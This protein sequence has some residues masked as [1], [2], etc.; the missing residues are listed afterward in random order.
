MK[1]QIML[2]SGNEFCTQCG[3][4][5]QEHYLQLNQNRWAKPKL[6]IKC[7][8][9]FVEQIETGKTPEPRERKTI[10]YD[11]PKVSKSS[12]MSNY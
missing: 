1:F 11:I 5:I 9:E 3:R 6:C 4:Q 10:I 12:W 8:K 7:L 2:D